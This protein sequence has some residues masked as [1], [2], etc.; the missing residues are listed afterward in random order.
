MRRF[1]LAVLAIG[2]IGGLVIGGLALAHRSGVFEGT[3]YSVPFYC[4]ASYEKGLAD[5]EHDGRKEGLEEGREEGHEKGR[6]EGRE[7]GRNEG[8]EEGRNEGRTQGRNEVCL[9]ILNL[10]KYLHRDLNSRGIC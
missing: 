9:Q 8:R 4:D 7:E 10:N 1:L 2:A 5:G 3:R 6:I